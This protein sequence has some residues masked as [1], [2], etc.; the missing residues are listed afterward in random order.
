MFSVSVN[1]W[2]FIGKKR[3]ADPSG[4][5]YDA[6]GKWSDKK[7]SGDEGGDF[8]NGDWR[9]RDITFEDSDTEGIGAIALNQLTLEAGTYDCTISAP[10]RDVNQ[11]TARLR[12]ITG[13]ATL[14]KGKNAEA[15]SGNTSDAVI[16]GRFTIG[17][18]SILQVQH[19]S[20]GTK[21]V[22]GFGKALSIALIDEVYTTI[23]LWRVA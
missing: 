22:S 19:Y 3:A 7:T 21:G 2:L 20:T 18:Q 15:S 13:G 14:L 9:Q 11:H 23:E 4:G 12:N 1:A 5:I 10:A 8:N 6:Y 16:N 17:I